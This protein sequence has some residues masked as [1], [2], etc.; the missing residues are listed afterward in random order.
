MF[1]I[2]LGPFQHNWGYMRDHWN[3]DHSNKYYI[4]VVIMSQSQKGGK[5]TGNENN[6]IRNQLWHHFATT[7]D[8]DKIT[9]N[10]VIK[11][12]EM[13]RGRL[14]ETSFNYFIA[15]LYKKYYILL[16]CREMV[17]KF[18]NVFLVSTISKVNT[19]CLVSNLW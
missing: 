18:K 7:K 6:P 15:T 1:V 12:W 10:S 8:D 13:E 9:G 11:T 4:P 14:L 17:A 19:W 2:V 5:F 16:H 3:K